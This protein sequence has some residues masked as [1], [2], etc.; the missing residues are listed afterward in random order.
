MKALTTYLGI[1]YK[2]PEE[3]VLRI[4]VELGAQFVGA[5][6]GSLLALDNKTNDLVFAMT[7]GSESSETALV[8]ERVPLGEGIVG[9]AAQMREVQIGAPT[10]HTR[11]SPEHETE[12]G[13]PS[14]VLAAPMLIG[15]SLIG[16]ITAVSFQ[17][18]KRFTNDDAVLYARIAT[19]AG[20]VVEQH[21]K[22]AAVEAL[23]KGLKGLDAISEDERLDFEIVRSVSRLVGA[24]PGAKEQVAHLLSILGSLVEAC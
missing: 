5:Q 11:Q 8:G 23:Q 20:V 22:L 12:G 10:Y 16:V 9:L 7:V 2:S 17:P 18:G 1:S 4:L 6:E 14:A 15:D 3:K 21:R 13:E 19:V 24:K